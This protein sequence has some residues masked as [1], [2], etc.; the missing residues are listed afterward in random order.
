[1]SKSRNLAALVGALVL[2]CATVAAQWYQNI[3]KRGA[4]APVAAVTAPPEAPASPSTS[5]GASAAPS[6]SPKPV[7]YVVGQQPVPQP[8]ASGSADVPAATASPLAGTSTAIPQLPAKASQG[9]VPPPPPIVV[10]SAAAPEI[11]S[12]SISTPVVR[13]GQTVMGNVETSTNVASVEARIGGY[14]SSLRKT[15]EG[16]FSLDYRV[17]YV[18]FFLKRTYT[19]QLIARNTR[20]DAVSTTFPIT[21]R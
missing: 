12:L 2:V 15:G 17:P 8:D 9:Y 3:V 10:S 5:P 16:H 19:V 1:M 20:G 11:V 13:S 7:V 14:S 4:N 6:P 18:P 21:V